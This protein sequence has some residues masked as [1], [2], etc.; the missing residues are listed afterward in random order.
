MM[1]YFF[2]YSRH[3]F[4]FVS[5][6][7]TDLKKEG[8]NVWLDQLN[9]SPGTRWDDAI[10]K[11]LKES[12]CMLVVISNTS[13]QSANVLDEISYALTNGKRVIPLIIHNCDVPFRIARLQHIDF[14]GDYDTAFQRLIKT[15]NTSQE[16]TETY[17]QSPVLE[18]RA[19][20]QVIG[21]SNSTIEKKNWTLVVAISLGLGIIVLIAFFLIR[22][23]NNKSENSEKNTRTNSTIKLS[24]N[25]SS[26]INLGNS[27]TNS[28]EK[29]SVRIL[30]ARIYVQFL[31]SE[32]HTIIPVISELRRRGFVVMTKEIRAGRNAGESIVSY[33]YDLDKSEAEQL[34]KILYEIPS[35]TPKGK[36]RKAERGTARRRHY[37][38]WLTYQQE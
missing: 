14:I 35:L 38:V 7:A 29:D 8:L 6:L 25:S 19:S 17:T 1:N 2:S 21:N 9:I 15:L 23:W 11:A 10:Q 36:I 3:D 20:K 30:P 31:K 13:V 16:A 28:T 34:L 24:P 33:H 5:R 22:N 12:D 26:S 4:D 37:D 32:S 27:S 18:N